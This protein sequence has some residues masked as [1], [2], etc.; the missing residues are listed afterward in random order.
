MGC[1]IFRYRGKWQKNFIKS[2]WIYGL[3]TCYDNET[4]TIKSVVDGKTYSVNPKTIGICTVTQSM[5]FSQEPYDGDIVRVVNDY[6]DPYGYTRTFYNDYLC[7]WNDDISA[8][9]FYYIDPEVGIQYD[10]YVLITEFEKCSDF[11]IIGNKYDNP[12][13]LR[14]QKYIKE[15]YDGL[16]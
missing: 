8:F 16:I 12:D 11:K 10:D 5:D 9:C 13:L 1:G 4:A 14:K 6:D 2:E 7:A 3:L 15:E